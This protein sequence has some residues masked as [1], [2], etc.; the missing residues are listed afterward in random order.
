L[1]L[2]EVFTAFTS[3]LGLIQ[4]KLDE[5]KPKAIQLVKIV[6]DPDA[7]SYSKVSRAT[8][9]GNTK[10]LG[11][12]ISFANPRDLDTSI[13]KII[14]TPDAGFKVNGMIEVEANEV[15]LFTNTSVADF[16]DLPSVTIEFPNGKILKRNK[17]LNIFIWS[18]SSV[19]IALTAQA[20]FGEVRGNEQ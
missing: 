11:A 2:I 15:S 9:T 19:A 16:T 3:T 14:L 13:S 4:K 8:T 6:F 7:F 17:K 18:P 5:V 10:A 20:V 12:T 1:S